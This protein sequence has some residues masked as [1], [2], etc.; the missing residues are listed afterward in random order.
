MS[1]R[2]VLGLATSCCLAATALAI[3]ADELTI[4][5]SLNTTRTIVGEPVELTLRVAGDQ[6]RDVQVQPLQLPAGWSTIAERQ[7]QRV[8]WRQG[9]RVRRMDLTVVLLP[10]AEGTFQLGPFT[11]ESQG[12][13]WR[14]EALIV[15]VDPAPQ[16]APPTLEHPPGGRITL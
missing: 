9:Q 6:L 14:T 15:V 2:S 12:K 8:T 16:T 13:S 11:V 10:Q 4:E 1:V 7:S 5:A 3:A